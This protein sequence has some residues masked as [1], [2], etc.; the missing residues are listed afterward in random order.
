M[1]Q[2]GYSDEQ[3]CLILLLILGFHG[4]SLLML[5]LLFS[6]CIFRAKYGKMYFRNIDETAIFTRR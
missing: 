2:K 5:I 1:S 6:L 3:I 4:S